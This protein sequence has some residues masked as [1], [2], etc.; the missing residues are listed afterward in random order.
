[1][2][3]KPDRQINGFTEP[4]ASF[5]LH[6]FKNCVQIHVVSSWEG[7]NIQERH[8][9]LHCCSFVEHVPLGTNPLYTMLQ[10][11]TK[12]LFQLEQ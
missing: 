9:G 1:M 10:A 11:E 4:K 6:S 8:R 2:E 5:V 7:Q 12:D 3:E